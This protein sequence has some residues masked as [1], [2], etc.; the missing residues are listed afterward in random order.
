MD[1]YR[2]FYKF[3]LSL[4]YKVSI[5][6]LELLTSGSPKLILPNHVSHT[7]PQLMWVIVGKYCDFVPLV[8]ERFF[9]IPVI[10]YYL[11]KSEAVKIYEPRNIRKAPALL[12]TINEHLTAAFKNKRSALIFPAGQLCDGGVEKVGNKQSAYSVMENIPEDVVV[13]GVR[14]KGMWGSI[15]SKARTGKRPP[16]FQTYLL[17]ILLVFLNLIFLC[18]KRKVT[19]EFVDITKEA[20]QNAKQGRQTFNRFLESFYNE[21]GPEEK[22]FVPHLFFFPWL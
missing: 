12:Q 11:R 18:P 17:S 16:F 21:Q 22:K 5:K 1:Y 3:I 10:K 13:V 14:I 7:D 19:L 8:A 6:G 20:K 4:R 2:R 9:K 15:W